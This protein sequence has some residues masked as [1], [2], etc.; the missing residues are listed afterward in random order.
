MSE[1]KK[2]EPD[3]GD[4]WRDFLREWNKLPPLIRA[5]IGAG[6]VSFAHREMLAA[7]REA[8]SL[9]LHGLLRRLAVLN[10][11]VKAYHLVAKLGA[12]LAAEGDAVAVAEGVDHAITTDGQ[13]EALENPVTGATD[14]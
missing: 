8:G 13:V 3:L 2:R 6:L 12:V 5:A 11:F 9:E 1:I 4:A 14:G 10:N 7:D